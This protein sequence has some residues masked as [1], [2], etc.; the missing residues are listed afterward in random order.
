MD[1]TERIGRRLKPRDLHV[2]MAVA[3]QRN[4]ALAAER[5]AISRPVVSKTIAQLEQILGV[6]LFDRLPSGV[7]PTVFG[8]ALARQSIVIFDELR[9]S[10]EEMEFLA[11][12]KRAE[13]RL[14]TGEVQAAGLVSVTIARLSRRYPKWTYDFLSAPNS[15]MR[16]ELLRSR[17]VEFVVAREVV[18]Q[19]DIDLEPLFD[20]RLV[21][22]AGK[23]STWA[24][25]RRLTLADLRSARWIQARHEIEPGGPT[26]AAFR[27]LG[28]DVPNIMILSNSLNLRCTLLT[29][30]DFVT[31]IPSSAW[32]FSPIRTFLKELPIDIPIWQR[33]SGILHLERP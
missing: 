20:E 8:Q 17:R 31:M 24:R 32:L 22:V 16:A 33:P 15:A 18:L 6:R 21:V 4:M 14:G 13:I 25:R 12:Q 10:V 27:Q 1:W 5:L 30:G 3:E 23:G 9:R 7:E 29:K 28:M 11:E 2:F 26:Y 19:H